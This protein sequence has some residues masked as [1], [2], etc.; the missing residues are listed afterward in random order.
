MFEQVCLRRG[1]Q[2]TQIIQAF[3]DYAAHLFNRLRKS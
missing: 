2:N 3:G 1:A